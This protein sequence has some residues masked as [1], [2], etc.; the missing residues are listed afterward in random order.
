MTL[1]TWNSALAQTSKRAADSITLGLLMQAHGNTI[2]FIIASF[3]S[4]CEV[5]HL[6]DLDEKFYHKQKILWNIA[7]KVRE[8][9]VLDVVFSSDIC[10]GL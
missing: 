8:L 3:G 1:P 6:V 5:V 2:W 10:C 4:N 7:K 9:L